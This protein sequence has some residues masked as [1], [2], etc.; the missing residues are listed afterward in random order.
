[1]NNMQALKYNWMSK[2]VLRDATVVMCIIL[3]EKKEV[4]VLIA[5][6]AIGSETMVFYKILSKPLITNAIFTRL[7]ANTRLLFNKMLISSEKR[8]E[9]KN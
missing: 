3:V 9:R 8:F 4:M 2:P 1:M 6:K 5:H 7:Y